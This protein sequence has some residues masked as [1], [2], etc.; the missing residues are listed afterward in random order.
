MANVRASGAKRAR[1]RG[2]Q[3]MAQSAP[4]TCRA[5]SLPFM[6]SVSSRLK[7]RL[8][9]DRRDTDTNNVPSR[10]CSL[11]FSL[12]RAAADADAGLYGLGL[13]RRLRAGTAARGLRHRAQH[14]PG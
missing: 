10:S 4:A 14:L 12:P 1:S 8:A 5:A 6:F 9:S 2:R 13:A 3:K 7:N 11:R